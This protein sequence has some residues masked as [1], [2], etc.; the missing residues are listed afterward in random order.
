MVCMSVMFENFRTRA[1][2]LVRRLR[3]DRDPQSLWGVIRHEYVLVYV[4]SRKLYKTYRSWPPFQRNHTFSYNF[5]TTLN[6]PYAYNSNYHSNPR[7]DS[8]FPKTITKHKPS[9]MYRRIYSQGIEEYWLPIFT[10]VAGIYSN[11]N[12]VEVNIV[13]ECKSSNKYKAEI[14]SDSHRYS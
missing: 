8:S 7:H 14:K 4:V 12:H 10:L 5:N 6:E 3:K 1:E 2:E 11:V 13:R 9:S